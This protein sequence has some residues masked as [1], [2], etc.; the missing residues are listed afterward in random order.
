MKSLP[1]VD[2]CLLFFLEYNPMCAFGKK[3]E[4]HSQ[5]TSYAIKFPPFSAQQIYGSELKM[6]NVFT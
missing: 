6:H 3:N 2:I 4:L 5:E 1:R